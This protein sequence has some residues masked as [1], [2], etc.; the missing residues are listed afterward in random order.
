MQLVGL[1]GNDII[2]PATTFKQWKKAN[3]SKPKLLLGISATFMLNFS[4]MVQ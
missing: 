1:R 3:G 2:Q 4:E